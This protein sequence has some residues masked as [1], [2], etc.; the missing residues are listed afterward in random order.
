VKKS[1]FRSGQRINLPVVSAGSLAVGGQ[2]KSSSGRAESNKRDLAPTEQ[3][4]VFEIAFAKNLATSQFS[5]F[6]PEFKN[7]DEAIFARK[8]GIFERSPG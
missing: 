2:R 6:S 8:S 3:N 1:F 4:I 5:T 7:C